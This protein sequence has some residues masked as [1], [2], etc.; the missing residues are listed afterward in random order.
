VSHSGQTVVVWF[1]SVL[2][3]AGLRA[4]RRSIDDI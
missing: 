2:A 3:V 4:L 1:V